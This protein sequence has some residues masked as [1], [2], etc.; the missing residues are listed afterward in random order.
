MTALQDWLSNSPVTPD[1]IKAVIRDAW[2]GLTSDET[3]D[4]GD[5]VPATAPQ[6]MGRGLERC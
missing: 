1:A 3:F 2:R 4:S 5:V 6:L